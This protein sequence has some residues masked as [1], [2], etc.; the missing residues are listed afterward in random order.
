VSKNEIKLKKGFGILKNYPIPLHKNDF[1]LQAILVYA[2]SRIEGAIEKY[3]SPEAKSLFKDK[4]DEAF[5]F[6]FYKNLKEDL[7]RL[8]P[9]FDDL[10][11]FILSLKNKPNATA[12]ETLAFR[13]CVPLVRSYNVIVIECEKHFKENTLWI[14]DLVAISL[15]NFWFTEYAKL[16][17]VY[18]SI[19][20]KYNFQNIL[21]RY[22]KIAIENKKIG[23]ECHIKKMYDIVSEIVLNL[24]KA[25]SKNKKRN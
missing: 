9:A 3:N 11:R 1:K 21:D 5:V 25:P 16:T 12:I 10:E 6:E 20:A 7:K 23:V 15:I 22:N 2:L 17:T 24:D 8:V 18:A 13:Q 14:P 4:I 19:V